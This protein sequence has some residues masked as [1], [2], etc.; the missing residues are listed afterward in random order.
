MVGKIKLLH[1][2]G[3][4]WRGLKLAWQKASIDSFQAAAM[5]MR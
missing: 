1:W 5:P 3:N 4:G 2:A